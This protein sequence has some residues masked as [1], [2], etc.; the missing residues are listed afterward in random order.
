MLFKPNT[1][2]MAE[3]A[4]QCAICFEANSTVSCTCQRCKTLLCFN[5]NRN[6]CCGLC[7]LCDREDL[8]IPLEC[9]H[10]HGQFH[11]RDAFP[12]AACAEYT[13]YECYENWKHNTCGF[14]DMCKD[15][16]KFDEGNSCEVCGDNIC[17]DC[18]RE[19]ITSCEKCC[20]Q[21]CTRCY[22]ADKEHDCCDSECDCLRHGE[23][24]NADIK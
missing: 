7:P 3:E 19:K 16:Y 23:P 21:L 5:C 11:V 22:E 9:I 8:N 24:T 15:Y 10:C 2:N 20:A 12:C 1:I 6:E 4:K 17:A 18:E 13:C 14:C